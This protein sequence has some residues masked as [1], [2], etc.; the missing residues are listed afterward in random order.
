MN[1]VRSRSCGHACA[2]TCLSHHSATLEEERVSR[3]GPTPE[4]T[5]RPFRKSFRNMRSI[6]TV[7]SRPRYGSRP[8]P[9]APYRV[10]FRWNRG[11][12]R[13][14]PGQKRPAGWSPFAGIARIRSL[15]VAVQPLR[16]PASQPSRRDSGYPAVGAVQLPRSPRRRYS[17]CTAPRTGAQGRKPGLHG[18][19]VM[20]VS[21]ASFRQR[22]G[23]V[24]GGPSTAFLLACPG[25][26]PAPRSPGQRRKPRG[27]AGRRRSCL[28]DPRPARSSTGGRCLRPAENRWPVENRS[29][30][31]QVTLGVGGWVS[32]GDW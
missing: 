5:R 18:Q 23:H 8:G 15:G 3:P 20:S 16:C 28:Q 12:D 21:G 22:A 11:R 6:M 17:R 10:R 1:I 13:W 32:C 26:R 2:L 30:S 29:I 9:G 24:P 4:I 7:P 25:P 14:P 27:L 31:R 19:N